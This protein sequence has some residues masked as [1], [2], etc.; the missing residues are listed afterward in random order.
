LLVSLA[1]RATVLLP[2]GK[3]RAGRA[4]PTRGAPRRSGVRRGTSGKT[5]SEC[6]QPQRKRIGW[7]ERFQ[8][9]PA[10]AVEQGKAERDAGLSRRRDTPRRQR[11]RSYEEL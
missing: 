7:R 10:I 1:V 9:V 6:E 2:L 11:R 3:R 4:G 8:A 5:G